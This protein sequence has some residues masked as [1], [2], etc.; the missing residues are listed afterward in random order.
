[1][2]LKYGSICRT[3]ACLLSV[4]R[5]VYVPRQTDA[6]LPLLLY[7]DTRQTDAKSESQKSKGNL[8]INFGEKV[9]SPAVRTVR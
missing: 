2:H 7:S 1:M 6:S 9:W 8:L 5:L 3:A 4:R